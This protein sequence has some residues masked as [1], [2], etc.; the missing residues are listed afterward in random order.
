MLWWEQPPP[1]SSVGDVHAHSTHL[2]RP[3]MIYFERG[4]MGRLDVGGSGLRAFLHFFA[5]F[6]FFIFWFFELF[7]C[8]ALSGALRFLASLLIEIASPRGAGVHA[9]DPHRLSF[10]F[11]FFSFLA[12]CVFFD[13]WCCLAFCV[14]WHPCLL[15]FHLR[16]ARASTLAIVVA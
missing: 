16:A 4:K 13:V 14:F 3:L 9:C 8:L 5:F 6:I 2:S 12:F 10:L 7:G 11:V 1:C 15:K